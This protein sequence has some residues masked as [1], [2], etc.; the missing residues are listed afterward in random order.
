MEKLEVI[1]LCF[2]SA[3]VRFGYCFV[4]CLSDAT[5]V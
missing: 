3:F 1:N 5:G 4:F 2:L